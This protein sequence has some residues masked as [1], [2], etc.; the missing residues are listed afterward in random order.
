M[1]G[2]QRLCAHFSYKNAAYDKYSD[3]LRLS[4]FGLFGQVNQ[5]VWKKNYNISVY[6]QWNSRGGINVLE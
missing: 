1:K 2:A 5:G 3:W 6:Q 4:T